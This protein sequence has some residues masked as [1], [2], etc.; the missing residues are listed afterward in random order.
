MYGVCLLKSEMNICLSLCLPDSLY[1]SC[2]SP[3]HKCLFFCTSLYLPVYLSITHNR[4]YV[5]VCIS[6]NLSVSLHCLQS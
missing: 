2:L 4:V 6:N 3:L 5:N 1:S